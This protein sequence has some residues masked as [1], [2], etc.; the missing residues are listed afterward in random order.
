MFIFKTKI[1]LIQFVIQLL[2]ID[3]VTY[4][5]TNSIFIQ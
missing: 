2:H 5:F 4:L 1:N 3:S